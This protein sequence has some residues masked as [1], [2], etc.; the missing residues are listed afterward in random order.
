MFDFIKER[1]QSLI[2]KKLGAAVIGETMVA[3]ASPELQGVPLIVYLSGQ[4]TVDAVK[5]YV[6][7][8]SSK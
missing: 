3:A 6:E 4:A 8:S 7:G 1:A 2:S 5:A